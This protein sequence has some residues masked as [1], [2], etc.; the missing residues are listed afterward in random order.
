MWSKELSKRQQP[1]ITFSRGVSPSC[2]PLLSFL[3]VAGNRSLR[4]ASAGCRG[5]VSFLADERIRFWNA[6]SVHRKAGG[7]PGVTCLDAHQVLYPS[8][9]PSAKT[10]HL[11]LHISHLVCHTTVSPSPGTAWRSGKVAVNIHS[12]EWESVCGSG[13]SSE[14]PTETRTQEPADPRAGLRVTCCFAS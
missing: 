3:L 9:Q 2:Q 13:S 8:R 1:A 4:T 7:K 5:N 11:C 6:G 10:V 14:R 12:G